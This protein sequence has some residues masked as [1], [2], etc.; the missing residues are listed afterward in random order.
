MPPRAM[1]RIAQLLPILAPVWSWLILGATST[2]S[3][4]KALFVM[5]PR[6]MF[7]DPP[8]KVG[9]VDVT[10]KSCSILLCVDCQGLDVMKGLPAPKNENKSM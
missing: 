7:G 1:A 6:G 10:R 3:E 4:G 2:T 5:D 8:S 9:T